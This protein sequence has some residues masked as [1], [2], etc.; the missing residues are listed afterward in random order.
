MSKSIKNA[1]EPLEWECLVEGCGFTW[2]ASW[3]SIHNKG[4]G[5]RRCKG[6]EEHTIE[7]IRE[8]IKGRNIDLISTEYVSEKPLIWKCLDPLCK[9]EWPAVYSSVIRR[10]SGCPECAKRKKSWYNPEKAENNKEEWIKIPAE[11]YFLHCF[12][13][14]KKESFYK[15]GITKNSVDRR[16]SGNYDM[17]Y[18]FIHIKSIKTNL[19]EA[20]YIED[21]LHN[22]HRSYHYTPKIKF[23]GSSLE[24]FSKIIYS[25]KDSVILEL[26]Y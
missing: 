15:I 6:Y 22:I 26:P 10:G 1:R 20:C 14:D 24:C 4:T 21:K 12:T 3:D 7:E 16:Y 11:V 5:C 23:G 18:E 2:P 19:Y 25:E 9:H 13:E 8:H 17:P